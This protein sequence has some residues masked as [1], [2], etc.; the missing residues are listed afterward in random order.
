M[1]SF[2]WVGIEEFH[3][4]FE[5]NSG[6]PGMHL[7]RVVGVSDVCQMYYR[8]IGTLFSCFL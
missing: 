2:Q 7:I 5:K 6:V 8:L 4:K 3:S 1:S